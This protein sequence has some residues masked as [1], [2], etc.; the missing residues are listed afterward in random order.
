MPERSVRLNKAGS[1]KIPQHSTLVAGIDVAKSRLDLAIHGRDDRLGT[2]NT[3]AGWKQMAIWLR[4][5]GVARVGMEA[6]GGYE[7]ELADT[8]R[9]QGFEVC[10]LQ[11]LQTKAFA[12]LHLRRAKN[13]A[14][15]ASLIAACTA[16][17]DPAPGGHDPR[18]A[19]CAD[20][21]TF[22]E[23]A[24]DDIARC[25]TRLEHIRNA[26]LRRMVQQDIARLTART[27]AELARI[28]NAL[29]RFDDLAQRFDL[30]LS[31]PGIGVRTTVAIVV[32][33]PE[34]GRVSR[35]QAAALA[36]LAPFDDDSGTH[37]G[38]RHIA[39]GRARLRRSLYAAALPAAFRWNPALKALYARLIAR[40]KS[41]KQALVACARKLLVY[42][43]TVVQR[44]TP[45]ITQP[46]QI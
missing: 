23:Q 34:L 14:I 44:G 7:R 17:I 25:K 24:E 42:A 22:V 41:H 38:Q 46:E 37:R 19:L 6:S 8:L 20:A 26:R 45:W 12:R 2:P 3:P 32:R 27:K 40:G 30:V 4:Q 31:V 39:G 28:V 29:R 36:G 43:N 10:L 35:E 13:D 18:L 1:K 9:E 16:I 15:D 21:L 11:P 33:M 5:A